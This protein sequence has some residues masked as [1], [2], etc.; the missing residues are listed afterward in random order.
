[1]NCSSIKEYKYVK[2]LGKGS[3][4][5]VKLYQKMVNGVCE[6]YAI[7]EYV[8]SVLFKKIRRFQQGDNIVTEC[9]YDKLKQE[10]EIMTLIDHPNCI[11]LFNYIE[12]IAS[13]RIYIIIEYAQ[14]GQILTWKNKYRRY[15]TEWGGEYNEPTARL[16]LKDII[17]GLEYCI[18]YY[19]SST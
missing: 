1:M 3:F 19:N 15:L 10:F 5:E 6:F 17:A 14:H 4:G 7:K 13:D 18:F 11:K 2:T 8:R 16:I 9:E 12:D